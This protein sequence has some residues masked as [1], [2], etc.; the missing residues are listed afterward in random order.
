MICKG[1]NTD[2][3]LVRSHIIPES[4]FRDLRG[5]EDTLKLVPTEKGKFVKRSPIG[6][7]DEEILCSECEKIFQEVDDYAAKKLLQ[8]KN[9]EEIKDNGELIGYKIND[10]DV[11][12]FKR[13]VISVLWRASISSKEFYRNINLGKIEDQAKQLIWRKSAG[14]PHEF[15]FVLGK[16]IDTGT[17]SKSI[18]D[19]HPEV[20]FGRRYYRFYMGGFVL[21]VKADS[22]LTP[23]EWAHFI[24]TDN[25]LIVISRGNI[26]N[27]TEFSIFMKRIKN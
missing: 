12:L 10:L 8:E 23:R 21:Y 22:Q 9:F 24:P 26:I 13:F 6:V 25:S 27:S 17:I 18:F 11:A 7:Y 15:S 14:H 4:F 19:P 2:R 3:K 5:D 1:C 20:W 16:F